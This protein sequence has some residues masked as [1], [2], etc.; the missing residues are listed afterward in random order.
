MRVIGWG[1]PEDCHKKKLWEKLF[2]FQ[3]CL[4]SLREEKKILQATSYAWGCF[5]R[6]SVFQ[7][8]LW[9]HHLLQLKN[10]LTDYF[11][12]S[13]HPNQNTWHHSFYRC[14]NAAYF[15]HT[16][17]NYF[18]NQTERKWVWEAAKVGLKTGVQYVKPTVCWFVIKLSSFFFRHR[19]LSCMFYLLGDF[20][21]VY[22]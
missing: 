7:L 14:K 12:N 13:H 5:S 18:I 20:L 11:C 9:S 15:P 10:T 17:L 1:L 4:A 6:M 22:L 3:V 16:V 19:S 21:F 8:K 2:L